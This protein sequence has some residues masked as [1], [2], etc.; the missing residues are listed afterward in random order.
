MIRRAVIDFV[1][2]QADA[3]VAVKQVPEQRD[4]RRDQ[5]RFYYRVILPVTGLRHG[6]F[7]EM[8]LTDDDREF[9]GVTIVRAHAQRK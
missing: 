2:T 5:Y 6:L 1:R 8:R 7:V 9:P 4:Q 3:A